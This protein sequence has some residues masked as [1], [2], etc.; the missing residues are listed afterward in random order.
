MKPSDEAPVPSQLGSAPERRARGVFVV[1]PAHEEE[2]R[3]V[4]TI[5]AVPAE[6]SGIVV[7]DDASTDATAE[8]V[9]SLAEPRLEL[10]RH[11]QNRGVGA[12]IASGYLRALERG[13]QVLVVMAGD[14]QM[15][16]ADLPAL[17]DAIDQGAAYAKGNRFLHPDARLMPR[18]RRL[19]S[20]LL[21]RLTRWL[22]GASFDDSQCGYTALSAAAARQLDLQT[23]WPRYGYPNDLLIQLGRRGL[24]IVE[25]PVRP[26][27]AGE[28][29]GLRPWHLLTIVGVI[30]RR[31]RLELERERLAPRL[32]APHS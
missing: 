6:V 20:W 28:R 14:A 22:A 24:D 9:G 13:A 10:L 1:I 31:W 30:L 29:S 25:V 11:E 32:T 2:E 12:A 17:L 27:Y 19:G 5:R 18:H 8:R 21:A 7:V 3:I 26:V 4:R 16:P 15:D 23:M